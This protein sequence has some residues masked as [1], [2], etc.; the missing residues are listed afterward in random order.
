MNPLT[1]SPLAPPL[2]VATDGSSTALLAQK[3]LYPLIEMFQGQPSQEQA[4]LTVLTVQPPTKQPLVFRRRVKALVAGIKVVSTP[5]VSVEADGVAD[6]QEAIAPE[7]ASDSQVIS[8]LQVT[9]HSQVTSD[10]QVTDGF[11]GSE[12]H[13][14]DGDFGD[15]VDRD[16]IP[17]F[18]PHDSLN[19]IAS[20]LPTDLSISFQ[21]RQGRPTIQ[22]LNHARSINAGLI[23]VGC[24]GATGAREFLL[25]SVSAAIARYAPCHVLVARDAAGE[26]STERVGE[27]KWGHV[28]LVVDASQATKQA[29][30]IAQQLLPVGI[31]QI[32]ILCVQPPLNTHYLYGPFVTPTPSWQL[33]KSLQQAQREQSEQIVHQAQAA[34]DSSGLTIHTLVQTSEPGPL[35]CHIAQQRQVDIVFLGSDSPRHTTS[36]NRPPAFRNIRLSA[37]ADY[38]IHHAPCPILLCRAAQPTHLAQPKSSKE[39]VEVKTSLTAKGEIS[40]REHPEH[41]SL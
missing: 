12:S 28:L 33:N 30:A 5:E 36:A 4:I 14:R 29:I 37:T 35:I 39:A 38:V 20:N 11:Q 31:Q 26:K 10:L 32:T 21:T 1:A 7:S 25:G 3:L 17:T 16:R 6:E 27:P 23:A 24:R 19:I 9:D 2:L 40:S 34:F 8:D 18:P 22:I 41:D 15:R 13:S